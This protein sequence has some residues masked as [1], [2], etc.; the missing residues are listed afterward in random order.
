MLNYRLYIVYNTNTVTKLQVLQILLLEPLLYVLNLASS[1]LNACLDLDTEY[2]LSLNSIIQS[3]L[4]VWIKAK[5]CYL[6]KKK[7]REKGKKGREREIH[8]LLTKA[9]EWALP[10]LPNAL[11]EGLIIIWK[12]DCLKL[13][14][15]TWSHLSGFLYSKIFLHNI[16][17]KY[18]SLL[19]PTVDKYIYETF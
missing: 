9:M 10:A 7:E 14:K 16:N 4:F 17:N 6:Q 18:F 13:I 1:T 15:G 19:K 5:K 8:A 12:N 11:N 3:C 2:I